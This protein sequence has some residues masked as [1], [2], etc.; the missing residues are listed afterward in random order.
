MFFYLPVYYIFFTSRLVGYVLSSSTDSV[1][2]PI[3]ESVRTNSA[4]TIGRMA[5]VAPEPVGAALGQGLSN[6]LKKWC[7]VIMSMPDDEEKV[8]VSLG[9]VGVAKAHPQAVVSDPKTLGFLAHAILSWNPETAN[10]LNN[11]LINQFRLLFQG[12]ASSMGA[13]NW[14][15]LKMTW[16][17]GA[18]NELRERLNAAFGV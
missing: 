14:N 11:D 12:F 6:F 9:L 7:L 8:D 2:V 5:M 10:S 1:G 18:A 15:Q 16:G 3:P 4:I 17:G 13:Q